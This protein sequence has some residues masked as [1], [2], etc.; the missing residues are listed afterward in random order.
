MTDSLALVKEFHEAFN[1]PVAAEPELIDMNR[2]NMRY[3]LIEE[4]LE[5]LR[6][7]ILAGD[8]IEIADALA[9]IKYVTDGMALEYGIPLNACT[10]EVHR[11]NMTKLGADGMPIYREDGKVMKGQNYEEPKLKEI[12]CK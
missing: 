10:E 2:A 3:M 4:E 7:A 11:S 6:D 9:D 12:L 8:I 5:E 1:H